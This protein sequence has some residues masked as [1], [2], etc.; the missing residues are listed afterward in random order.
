MIEKIWHFTINQLTKCSGYT[1]KRMIRSDEWIKVSWLYN[2]QRL[3]PLQALTCFIYYLF[4][5][6]PPLLEE[7]LAIDHVRYGA[8][9]H[10]S[11]TRLTFMETST[12]AINISSS[13][14]IQLPT[15]IVKSFIIILFYF[16]A[17]CF[18]AGIFIPVILLVHS[19][20]ISLPDPVTYIHPVKTLKTLSF[21]LCVCM[22]S[23]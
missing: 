10:G 16:S 9:V 8:I 18:S 22:Q 23:L 3:D 12:L 7:A 11:R 19:A 17:D 13:A 20:L 21:L 2:D 1:C 4:N 5:G 6:E 15:L 14:R